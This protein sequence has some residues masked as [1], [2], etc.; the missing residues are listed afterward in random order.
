MLVYQRV[1]L[2]IHCQRWKKPW[3]HHRSPSNSGD[4]CTG[5]ASASSPCP[6]AVGFCQNPPMD[7]WF[8][9][10]SQNVLCTWWLIP[11]SKW[12]ITPVINGIS[13]VNPLITGVITR[14]LS[15]MSHQV[16]IYIYIHFPSFHLS[17]YIYISHKCNNSVYVRIHTYHT[18][19]CHTITYIHI[20]IYIN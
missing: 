13:K 5:R 9:V 17:I 15:G 7:G 20:Y 1:S 3:F 4:G 6:G 18:I 11:L 16:C 10:M 14:L 8:L 12:V 19:S 2:P